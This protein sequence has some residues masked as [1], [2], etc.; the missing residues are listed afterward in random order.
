MSLELV[1]DIVDE[2]KSSSFQD[3]HDVAL[4][5]VGENGESSLHPHLID[6]LR[7][8][9][10][11]G[12][13]IWLF[14]NFSKLKHKDIEIILEEELIHCFHVNVDGFTQES[15]KAVKG[16]DFTAREALF[17]LLELRGARSASLKLHI[18][19]MESYI[20]A[21]KSCEAWPHKVSKDVNIMPNE[22]E[23]IRDYWQKY[24]RPG[25]YVG[26]DDCI[27]WAER[28]H[29]PL[30]ADIE[31]YECPNIQRI[32]ECAYIAPDGVWYACCL[33]VENKLVVGNVKESSIDEIYE[34]Q[35]RQ[36]L[37][38]QLKNRL[39]ND[40]G[41]PCNRVDCCYVKKFE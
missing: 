3:K 7:I 24:L 19:T 14:S 27:A 8:I 28:D 6:A 20:N 13:P 32:K 2:L 10:T 23:L 4:C 29:L 11:V 39:F 16:I 38:D 34:S 12:V 9:K 15:Y 35:K 33:D 21:I 41:G 1:Q 22:A 25:D 5:N 18:I 31:T 26:I 17:N 37:I 30:K 40:I 36:K